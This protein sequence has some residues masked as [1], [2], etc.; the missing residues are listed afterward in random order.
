MY[1]YRRQHPLMILFQFLSNVKSLVLP[2]V[3]GAVIQFLTGEPDDGSKV[4]L[5]ISG[6]IITF[7]MLYNVLGWFFYRY[8]LKED[9]LHIKSGI[10]I[11]HR[12]HI[13]R[14]RVQTTN[15]EAGIL[16]RLFGLYRLRIETA[17]SK[18]ES[19]FNMS[20]LSKSAAATIQ[21]FMESN[22]KQDIKQA[23]AATWSLSLKGLVIAGITSGGI[24]FVFSVVG[25]IV[26]QAFIFLPEAWL[27]RFYDSVFAMSFILVVLVIT[28]LLLVSWIISVIR[29]IIRFAYFKVVKNQDEIIITRG[30]IVKR[31]LRLKQHRIQAMTVVQ[32]LLREPFG[33]ATLELEVAGG[34]EYETNY[35]VSL[36]PLIAKRDLQS[37]IQRFLPV[38]AVNFNLEP[39]PKR[40]QRRYLVRSSLPYLLL[41]P[42]FIFWPRTLWALL[43]L[44]IMWVL[45]C[46][47]FKNGGIAMYDGMLVLRSRMVAKTTVIALREHLQD[48]TIQQ[49]PFQRFK[50]LITITFT[51]MSSPSH[52]TFILKDVERKTYQ[53]LYDW[54]LK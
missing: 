19:E 16:H 40:A 47:R 52:R 13:K 20:A 28:I 36:C 8:D 25:F 24:G 45:G 18:T 11:K 10:I 35:K 46:F 54:Y 3:I 14:A 33:L 41:I 44:P 51:V 15:V 39:L 48:I 17:G 53:R 27:D 29:Y 7:T 6:G 4:F 12:R 50:D 23:A 2:I 30:L 26:S 21:T 42:V 37:F 31:V 38:Y 34:S 43:T 22:R 5:A 49:N 9:A 32:G 1:N